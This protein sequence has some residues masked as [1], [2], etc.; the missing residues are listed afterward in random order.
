L[1]EQLRRRRDEANELAMEVLLHPER[2]AELEPR[3]DEL[4]GRRRR[5]PG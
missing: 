2:R 5:V 3:I 1:A 4:L